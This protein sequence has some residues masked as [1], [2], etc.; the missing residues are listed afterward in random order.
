MLITRLSDLADALH[1]RRSEY[2]KMPQPT[3]VAETQDVADQITANIGKLAPY[4]Y[5]KASG[6]TPGDAEKLQTQVKDYAASIPGA[7]VARGKGKLG[8]GTVRTVLKTLN[9]YVNGDFRSAVELLVDEH[10]NLYKLLRDAMRIDDTGGG[11]KAKD[12]GSTPTP[13]A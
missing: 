1:I 9:G 13:G 3:L 10:P 2:E 4:G 5:K 11:K 8:T 7:G 6:P 12:G